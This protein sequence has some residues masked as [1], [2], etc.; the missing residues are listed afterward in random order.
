VQS[1]PH[2]GEATRA[3]PVRV[4]IADDR[5]LIADALRALV[6]TLDGFTVAA[7]TTAGDSFAA[8]ESQDP[9]V[10]VLCVDDDAPEAERRVQSLRQHYPDLEVVLL[11]DRLW[12]WLIGLV[13]DHGVGGVL[14]TDAAAAEIGACLAQVAA[15]QA[16]LPSGWKGMLAAERADP[17]DALSAR[18]MEV[19]RLLADGCSYDEIARRL[20]ISQNTVKFHVR[21]IFRRLGVR[22]RM[23][24]ARLLAAHR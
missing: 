19:L 20:F 8:V 18:Q 23:A 2:P 4:V 21:S 7:T 15:G 13:L 11:A 24:A 1:A 3:V 16:V 6:E 10:L 5:R 17:L 14:I 9:H 22:N 12:P